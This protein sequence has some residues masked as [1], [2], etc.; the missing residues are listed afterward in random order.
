MN[1]EKFKEL[2]NDFVSFESGVLGKVFNY[3]KFDMH[4]MTSECILYLL[5]EGTKLLAKGEKY[6]C[7]G[8]FR[9]ASLLIP[10]SFNP[11]KKTVGLDNWSKF[12]DE[13]QNSGIVKDYMKKFGIDNVELFEM[14]YKEFFDTYEGKIGLLFADGDHTYDATLDALK[15]ANKIMKKN[16]VIIIDDTDRSEVKNAVN[17]FLEG[18]TDFKLIWDLKGANYIKD[19]HM[20]K[21][22]WS[23]IMVLGK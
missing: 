5:S 16:S 7:Y 22:W 4:K 1:I 19:R 15:R 2:V 21:A 14:D 20:A 3:D 17:K 12:D 8:V 18:N 11:T 9:G 13:K 10:A 6:V 23:G